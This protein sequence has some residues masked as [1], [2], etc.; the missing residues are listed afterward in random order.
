MS[1]KVYELSKSEF[2]SL[3]KSCH[4]I[5]EVLFKLNL[6]AVGNSWAYSLVKKR[7]SELGL[8]GE[9][10]IGKS[11]MISAIKQNKKDNKE[12]F[13]EHS[14]TSR[15]VAR[16]KIIADNLIE[17]K[18]SCCGISE[19]NGKPLSLELDHINGINDDHRLNNLRFLCPNCH[20]QTETYG[21]RNFDSTL[22]SKKISEI[23]DEIR[24]QII[25]S[26]QQLG[27]IKAVKEQL[28]V[29]TSIIALVIKDA[30]L[31]KDSNQ[32]GVVRYDLEGNEIARF[33]SINECCQTL[34]NNNELKTK[35]IKTARNTFLRNYKKVWLKSK[36]EIIPI[37]Q[38]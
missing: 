27:S 32:K 3:I 33:G 30:G 11:I 9:D 5:K 14:S 21:S 7:M 6:S 34:I 38:C 28:K 12:V 31:N 35:L 15:N 16:R 23:S 18:C 29:K 4:N 19:W 37:N 25:E 24:A 26:Y 2:E 8:S 1:N 20:S 13:I 22:K 17:Y 36:W 10:F